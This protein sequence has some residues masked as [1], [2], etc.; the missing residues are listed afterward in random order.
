MAT[1]NRQIRLRRDTTARW[2]QYNPVL[3]SGEFGVDINTGDVRFGFTGDQ[4]YLDLP[5]LARIDA[6]TRLFE[7]SILDALDARYSSG[8]RPEMFGAVADYNHTTGTGTD[9]TAAF[10]AAANAVAAAG[11]GLLEFSPGGQYGCL[12][13]VLL[14]SNIVVDFKGGTFNKLYGGTSTS[15]VN[16]VAEG[17]TGYGSG[18]RNITLQNGRI[19]G[20]YDAPGI[21]DGSTGWN[22]VD[23]LNFINMVFEELQ[24]NAHAMDLGGCRNVKVTNCTFRGLKT[25]SG[26]EYVEAIQVDSSSY[27]GS[28]WKTWPTSS[29]DGLPTR[30][31]LVEGCTF[32]TYTKGA[33]TYG[34]PSPIGQHGAFGQDAAG[35]YESIRFVNNQVIGFNAP[36]PGT[37]YGWLHFRSARNILIRGNQF[38]YT[39]P[40]GVTG[41]P[42]VISVLSTTVAYAIADASNPD[43]TATSFTPPLNPSNVSIIGNEFKGFQN[44]PTEAGSALI[45]IVGAAT[46]MVSFNT[47]D[48][49]SSSFVTNPPATGG[50]TNVGLTVQGNTIASN[51]TEPVILITSGVL[52]Q[53]KD[54]TIT[55]PT[56]G[57]G[58]QL[59]LCNAT[60]AQGNVFYLGATG[61]LVRGCSNTS[62]QNNLAISQT[63]AG[64]SVGPA[65]YGTNASD[66]V[67]MGNR[68]RATGTGAA[69]IL[70]GSTSSRTKM[71]ANTLLST[72]PLS[73]SGDLSTTTPVPNI[74][75]A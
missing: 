9:N 33:T 46:S 25:V 13:T 59:D 42:T 36:T 69:G 49:L 22:H 43:A 7:Q 70:L 12:G 6:T 15:F 75:A 41:K 2:A 61:I 27:V 55:L 62:L 4:H 51:T 71:Q 56:N 26:R 68:S 20:N 11:A 32:T 1:E 65:G 64:Y 52:A 58:V 48:G 34:M 47:C 10:N 31:V 24:Q 74:V 39:G 37:A 17:A 72:V 38:E 18:A 73:Q 23:N 66:T 50:N 40:T 21:V 44:A 19:R 53:V 63:V 57:V 8:V 16:A 28:S 67:L 54:N 14:P 3:A 5:V 45:N 30:G 60:L 35:Y 29:Y